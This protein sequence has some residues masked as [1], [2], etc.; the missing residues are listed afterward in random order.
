MPPRPPLG[1]ILKTSSTPPPNGRPA[2]GSILASP[3]PK[4]SRP[5]LD[6]IMTNQNQSPPA[7]QKPTS[8]M[9]ALEQSFTDVNKG[10]S[11]VK[12]FVQG[13]NAVA[14]KIADDWKQR[15][16][17]LADT[18]QKSADDQSKGNLATKTGA[19]LSAGLQTAGA[20]VGGAFD[21]VKEGL[22]PLIQGVAD[23]VSNNPSLQKLAESDTAGHILNA[24]P[25]LS[26][27]YNNW[28]SQNPELARNL[29]ATGNIVMGLTGNTGDVVKDVKAGNTQ[30]KTD[31]FG[32]TDKT[33]TYFHGADAE[34]AA[35]IKTSGFQGSKE[36]PG[37]GM[38][39]LTENA[40]TAGHYAGPDGETLSVK[41]TPQNTKVYNSME[42]YTNA[43]DSQ[44]GMTG[45]EAEQAANKPYDF[46][47][48]KDADGAGNDLIL[49][50]PEVLSVAPEPKPGLVGNIKQGINDLTQ[51]IKNP[52]PAEASIEKVLDKYQQAV[53]PS[54][55]G[56]N[57]VGATEVYNQKA[58]NGIKTIAENKAN[59]NFTSEDGEVV[60]GEV[61]KNLNDFASSIDQTKGDIYKQYNTLAK[62][63]GDKGINV[64]F[65]KDVA[66]ELDKIISNKALKISHP[67]A[68][69]YAEGLKERLTQAGEVDP[70][71]AEEIVQN[72]NNS[73]K[74]FYRNPTYE[75][76]SRASIDAYIVNK[77]RQVLDDAITGAT[78]KDYQALKTKYGE[79]KT[80]ENDVVKAANRNARLNVKG[81]IDYTKIFSAGDI[82]KGIM[83]ADPSVIGKGIMERAATSYYKYL[84]D[85]NRAIQKMFS[86]VDTK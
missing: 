41:A 43:I 19:L 15:A 63:A 37:N 18:L 71:T 36:F 20:G 4:P 77:T 23:N 12:S 17:T 30:I 58:F 29:E 1:Q 5:S 8:N 83:G 35:Q 62:Q 50:K 74:S 14:D 16:A 31:L 84:N 42:D 61:P 59:L 65:S 69:Q 49:A 60:K 76:T 86:L 53:K 75:A 72:Y 25:T 56:K 33:P 3:A 26:K 81:L 9:P 22:N 78:G 27:I 52:T 40:D 11:P 82:V 85:P 2:L 79:L 48:I 21:V 44:K 70:E 66:P 39:S 68:V 47:R 34:T 46:V 67:E 64:D 54:I 24:M 28:A 80:I 51:K 7:A 57:T 45:G 38:V 6:D 32:T 73:L 55:A 13:S 10:N